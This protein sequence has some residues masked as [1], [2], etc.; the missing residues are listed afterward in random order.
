MNKWQLAIQSIGLFLL[1][2][3][4]CFYLNLDRTLAHV[5][6][7]DVYKVA[8]SANYSQD[9]TLYMLV[10]G[11]LFKS[12]NGGD[13]WQRLVNG[14]DH[15]GNLVTFTLATQNNQILYLSSL[16]DG[17]YK[18]EDRGKSWFKVNRGLD[19]LLIDKLVT[20]AD[21]KTVLAAG[22]DKGLYLS[23]DGGENWQTIIKDNRITALAIHPQKANYL[24]IG[25]SQGKIYLSLDSG[26]TWQEIDAFRRSIIG[27]VISPDYA[28]DSTIAVINYVG[29]AY[30][31][32]DGG[33]TWQPMYR[34]LELPS[35]TR[36]FT[37]PS[38]EPRRFFQMAISP[39]YSEDGTI[40]ASLLWTKFLTYTDRTQ[41]W[42]ISSPPQEA[43]SM[44]IAVSPNFARD[45]TIY[46]AAQKGVIFKSTNGGKSFTTVGKIDRAKGNESP[47][48]VI[49]PN[50]A[51][52][53][54]LYLT[55]G[56]G[57]YK[58]IDRGETWQ[59]TT[60]NSLLQDRFNL[61]L[62]I[63]PNYQ[64]DQAKPGSEADRTVMASTDRGL[65]ITDNGGDS[66][67]KLTNP[68][69]DRDAMLTGVAISPNYGKDKTFLISVRGKG[70]FKTTDNGATFQAV[71]DNSF[72][73]A[74]LNN[75]E[76]S[77]IPIQFSPDY[78]NDLTIYGIGS[79]DSE[80]YKSTDG[81]E[82]WLTI[83]IPQA[84]IFRQYIDE[85]YNFKTSLRLFFYVYQSHIFKI[86]AA[87]VAAAI[88]YFVLGYLNLN[89]KLSLS[90][91]KLQIIG[92]LTVLI[93]S[94]VVLFS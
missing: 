88:S 67:Q 44:A 82:T 46:L 71:G 83:T 17:I 52:D 94:A 60:G 34:G 57:I 77:S 84:E 62:A 81:G 31:S 53:G 87:L 10:R 89:K 42:R 1:A 63:S 74:L 72:N 66:W 22:Y 50:F 45:R 90:K 64:F 15:H 85:Q 91:I 24:V 59:V 75:F 68:T 19:N 58:S 30:I 14:I 8:L 65:F 39:N 21:G 70:L 56:K 7:D 6:H 54:T 36:K 12:T 49:S 32:S 38:I 26:K 79:A 51:S 2:I 76:S 86:I 11:N 13:S 61:K 43:R 48:L 55:G 16:S 37:P 33:K 80:I 40:F 92:S 29:E 78:Q 73:L 18:S 27:L 28:N 41:R 47:S 25:T 35:I 93:L 69:F 9:R 3:A 4:A 20:S 5:P 23:S